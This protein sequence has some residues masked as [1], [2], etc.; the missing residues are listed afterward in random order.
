MRWVYFNCWINHSL[1]KEAKAMSTTLHS[2]EK[3]KVGRPS[4]ILPYDEARAILKSKNIKS[5]QEY[6]DWVN[7]TKPYGFSTNPYQ[8]YRYRGDWK[9]TK[10]FLGL[11]DYVKPSVSEDQDIK[12]Q[13]NF[14]KIKQIIKQILRME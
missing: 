14:S 4:F 13:L 9:G 5:Y 3:R 1:K 6:L 7:E 12:G 2:E 11:T 10:H 8:I